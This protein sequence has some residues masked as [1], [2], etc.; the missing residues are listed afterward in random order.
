MSLV[1]IPLPPL[2]YRLM[3]GPM[4]DESFSNPTGALAFPSLPPS[5]Y[6]SVFDFGCGCGRVARKLMLQNP[7]PSRYVGLDINRRMIDWCAKNL[8]A[9][10]P[11]F[12]FV[13]HD[14]F[15]PLLGS[16]NTRRDFQPFPSEDGA[17]SLAIA[18]SVFTH[19][20]P[21]QAERYLA[22]TSRILKTGGLAYYSWFLFD[23]RASPVFK[24][25]QVFENAVYI[26]EKDPTA[27]VIYDEEFV[28]AMAQAYGLEVVNR[29]ENYQVFVTFKKTGN[30][31]PRLLE[32]FR[33]VPV[34]AVQGH[35]AGSSG[36]LE[37]ARA[38][39]PAISSEDEVC[40]DD[41]LHPTE[42][43]PCVLAVHN[44]TAH[45]WPT[46]GED[47]VR[48]RF[49]WVRTGTNL[50]V[51]HQDAAIPKDSGL[52][53]GEQVRVPLFVAAPEIPGSY[54]ARVT[55]VRANREIESRTLQNVR[56]LG[57]SAAPRGLKSKLKD[58]ISLARAFF[59]RPWRQG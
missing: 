54:E 51:R 26:S 25:M 6:E 13:H 7:K 41:L 36:K 18:I 12:Q 21:E 48:I 1:E 53:P 34:T 9:V 23:K 11:V 31:N 58:A 16:L 4:D 22:E 28:R 14:V 19:L 8:S 38:N 59:G 35:G 10:D 39:V 56:V 40:L 20:L 55:L 17:F 27:A 37:V 5:A 15:N 45:F 32:R 43:A 29:E 3:V 46:S 52:H 2:R 50:S 42:L 24:M 33:R 30:P 49:S 47:P 44:N 57:D